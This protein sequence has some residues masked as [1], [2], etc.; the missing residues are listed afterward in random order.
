MNSTK[1]IA[2]FDLDKTIYN[3]YSLFG[4]IQSLV[5]DGTI[6][7]KVLETVISETKKYHTGEQSYSDAAKTA[8]TV[9]AKSLQGL[10]YDQLLKSAQNSFQKNISNFYPYFANIL[11]TLKKTHKVYLITTNFQAIAETVKNMFNLD[12]YLCTQYEVK[13]GKFTGEIVSTLA[14]GK[15]V[16]ESLVSPDDQFSLAV[17]DSENDISMLDKVKIP[18]CINPSPELLKVATERNWLVVDDHTAQD[19]I[20]KVLSLTK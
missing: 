2:L 4:F 5:E 15:D 13:D 20:L 7:K 9:F 17:G 12:G 1:S 10:T 3:N 18:I 6:D 8:L 14:D 11:P 19:Q 16:V